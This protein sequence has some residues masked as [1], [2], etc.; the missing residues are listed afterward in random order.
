MTP[1]IAGDRRATKRW[2]RER[3]RV[4]AER[5]SLGYLPRVEFGPVESGRAQFDHG[6]RVITIDLD[7][8]FCRHDADDSAAHEVAHARWPSLPCD[9][10]TSAPIHRR[11]VL[12]MRSGVRCGPKGSQ[13]PA[14]YR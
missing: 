7:A 1:R 10:K 13:L 12:A 14:E 8:Q 2:I 5:V 6:A 11:R 4:Y 9:G 3:V